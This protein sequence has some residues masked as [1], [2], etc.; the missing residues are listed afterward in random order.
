MAKD[1]PDGGE[2]AINAARETLKKYG[3]TDAKFGEALDASGYEILV[4]RPANAVREAYGKGENKFHGLDG[5]DKREAETEDGARLAADKL[6]EVTKNV[7]PET[8]ILILQEANKSEDGQGNKLPKVLDAIEQTI[9]KRTAIA[10][11]AIPDHRMGGKNSNFSEEIKLS[12]SLGNR[13]TVG[14]YSEIMGRIAKAPQGESFIKD[15]ATSITT[16][17]KTTQDQTFAD[18]EKKLPEETRDFTLEEKK[19]I[20]KE[21]GIPYPEIKAEGPEATGEPFRLAIAN[22]KDPTLTLAVVKQLKE[23]GNMG[24]AN[25]IFDAAIKG[26]NDF[27]KNSQNVVGDFAKDH[28]VVADDWKSSLSAK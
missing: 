10:S 22:G 26:T 28:L 4:A 13:D 21:M 11:G 8:A 18:W 12:L 20:G 9:G 1:A 3:P 14:S 19:M 23:T 17:I 27:T 24:G 6:N 7:T 16:A 15:R 2:A 5:D 25:T